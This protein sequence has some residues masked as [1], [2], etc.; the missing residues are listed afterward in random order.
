MKNILLLTF[1][2]SLT[3]YSFTQN[4]TNRGYKV[5]LGD[6]VPEMKMKMRNGEIWTNKNFENM[7]QSSTLEVLQQEKQE[8]LVKAIARCAILVV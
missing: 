1:F 6:P 2:I 8:L 7:H 4:E 3:N 5:H